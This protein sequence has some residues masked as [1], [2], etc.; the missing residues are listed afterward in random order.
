MPPIVT[1]HSTTFSVKGKRKIILGVSVVVGVL[2]IY[3]LF[4][5]TY[6]WS[7]VFRSDLVGGRHGPL[8][9]Y[10]HALASAVVSYTLDRRAVDVVTR[11]MEAKGKDSNKMDSQN[12]RIGARI[13]A[14]AKSFHELEPAVRK[15]VT[16]GTI[17]STNLNQITWLPNEKW[18]DGRIW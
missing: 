17:N 1:S 15:L 6:T 14:E 9:A 11:L 4:V 2:S 10:R 5:L 16:N 18:R 8:D 3:P 7:Q 12:N 13:G